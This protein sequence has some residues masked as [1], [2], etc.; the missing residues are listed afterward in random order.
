MQLV[1]EILQVDGILFYHK[2][3]HYHPGN[4][5]LVGWL[6]VYMIPEIIGMD[7]PAEFL[8][9]VPKVHKLTLLKENQKFR[10]R[11]KLNGEKKQDESE[12]EVEQSKRKGK[13]KTKGK[14]MIV[15]ENSGE[16]EKN[17]EEM[18]Q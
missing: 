15:D 14:Q 8:C 7:V 9:N 17:S 1:F 4:T 6:K 12:M 13:K 18:Q 3:A 16:S 10:E 2:R 5:P 11:S